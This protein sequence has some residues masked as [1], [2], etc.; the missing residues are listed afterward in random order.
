[1]PREPESASGMGS[2]VIVRPEGYI[3][4]NNHVVEADELNVEL[5]DGRKVRGECGNRPADGPCGD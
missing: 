4:T 1:M 3:L 5:A 2:G